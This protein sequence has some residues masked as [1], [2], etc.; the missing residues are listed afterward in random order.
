M[1]ADLEAREGLVGDFMNDEEL[2]PIWDAAVVGDPANGIPPALDQQA[3][4]EAAN[5][6]NT[7]RVEAGLPNIQNTVSDWQRSERAAAPYQ[8]QTAEQRFVETPEQRAAKQEAEQVRR[9]ESASAAFQDQVVRPKAQRNENVINAVEQAMEGGEQSIEAFTQQV[10]SIS[11][12]GLRDQTIQLAQRA[13]MEFARPIS[14]SGP[15]GDQTVEYPP[16]GGAYDSPAAVRLREGIKGSAAQFAQGGASAAT[17]AAT[18]TATPAATPSATP[19]ATPATAPAG[20]RSGDTSI[21]YG[22]GSIP[23]RVAAARNEVLD[24]LDE[25]EGTSAMGLVGDVAKEVG[26]NL[27]A[28]GPA[29]WNMLFKGGA[30]TLGQEIGKVRAGEGS[31]FDPIAE[32]IAQVVGGTTNQPAFSAEELAAIRGTG[33]EERPASYAPGGVFYT[34]PNAPRPVPTQPLDQSDLSLMFGPTD[35]ETQP[36]TAEDRAS[37]EARPV[38]S[39][40]LTDAELASLGTGP[41]Q[42]RLQAEYY[43]TPNQNTHKS[44]N[45]TPRQRKLLADDR[46]SMNSASGLVR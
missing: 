24:F 1:R 16:T 7:E 20:A 39:Q 45:L 26:G 36:L 5:Q 10:E 30:G 22:S 38:S 35:V 27:A 8:Q 25:S 17:P 29:I 41:E 6:I 43:A 15:G 14:V 18:P 44:P 21:N 4:S 12:T 34:D 31:P 32:G 2:R 37:L 46:A 40:A 9:M 42:A 19:S 33:D 13:G 28:T 3:Q 11:D 23:E